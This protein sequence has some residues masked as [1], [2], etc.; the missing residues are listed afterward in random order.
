MTSEKPCV[1]ALCFPIGGQVS[2]CACFEG[3]WLP[4]Q[5]QCICRS[6]TWPK[7]GLT[8]NVKFC[9]QVVF[10][11]QVVGGNNAMWCFPA[12]HDMG[13]GWGNNAK[14]CFAATY[15]MLEPAITVLVVSFIIFVTSCLFLCTLY[16]IIVLC[17]EVLEGASLSLNKGS[18][19]Q[20]LA[21]CPG[22]SVNR[23]LHIFTVVGSGFVDSQQMRS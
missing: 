6:L 3:Q 19:R 2:K 15:H 1:E 10:S 5:R 20:L 4:L 18:T 17:F 12:P 23:P 9:D 16:H 7:A 21:R 13:E 14:I 8:M 11:R 22:H